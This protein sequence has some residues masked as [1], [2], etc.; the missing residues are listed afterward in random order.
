[1]ARGTYEYKSEF[2][3]KYFKQ[4][5]AR[6]RAE[7]ILSVLGAR[8]ISVSAEQR[9]RILA[10]GDNEKLQGWMDRAFTIQ[11]TEELFDS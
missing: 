11:E 10:S 7:G 6:G 8:G 5:E 4:G 2:A 3:R 1:M 9:S